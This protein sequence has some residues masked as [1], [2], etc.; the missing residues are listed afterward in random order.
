MLEK[1]NRTEA[2]IFGGAFVIRALYA[3]AIQITAG[4]HGFISFSDAKAFYYQAALNL[5]HS[6]IFSIAVATPFYPEAYHTPLYPLFIAGLMVL[7]VPLFG[8]VLAQDII[9]AI[10]IV[11]IYRVA[12]ML[13]ES[14]GIALASAVL[15]SIEPMS[16]YWS[17]LLMS[18]SFFAF[19]VILAVYFLV[20]RCQNASLF[21]LGFAAL[22]RPI[23]LYFMPLF[24]AMCIYQ[25]YISD[26]ATRG[27]IKKIAIALTLFLVVLAPWSLRNK[28]VFNTWSL[29]SAGWYLF[30]GFPLSEFA[31]TYKLPVVPV[32]QPDVGPDDF[33]RFG[34]EYTPLYKKAFFETIAQNPVGFAI[35]YAKRSL[36][37]L[38]TDRY[39]YLFNDVLSSE[40]PSVYKRLPGAL[41]ALLLG[42]G[43]MFWLSIYILTIL[44][45]AWRRLWPWW[46]FYISLFGMSLVFSAGI[47]PAGLDMSRYLL[48]IFPFFFMFAAIGARN[49]LERMAQWRS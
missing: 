12:L 17:G 1:S 2:Y 4:A 36:Y 15:A 29:S 6:H 22:T 38:V 21:A 25:L 43:Q 9:C 19:F 45:L 34:F 10:T 13:S 8:I 24:V 7:H 41:I 14:R 27:I 40:L 28:A 44:G 35:V 31:H 49:I 20:Q 30:Y 47:N 33:H 5:L 42:A 26:E 48:H 18:D 16:I 37:G 3:I 32:S 23:A 39:D 46:L 11:L